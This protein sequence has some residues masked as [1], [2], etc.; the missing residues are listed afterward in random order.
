VLLPNDFCA[1]IKNYDQITQLLKNHEFCF[2]P[3]GLVLKVPLQNEAPEGFRKM[4]IQEG[5]EYKEQLKKLLQ[6]W[7]IVAFETG[8]IDGSGYGYKVHDSYGS[9]CGEMFIVSVA[10][11]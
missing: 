2:L 3:I 6:T 4:L 10:P 5:Y 8:K 9:E 1:N 7:S 11:I